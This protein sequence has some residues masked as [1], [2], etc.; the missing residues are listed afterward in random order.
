LYAAA[1]FNLAFEARVEELQL[2]AALSES[3]IAERFRAAE[4]QIEMLF[5]QPASLDAEPRPPP[6]PSQQD[7]QRTDPI[8]LPLPRGSAR[9]ILR[10]I[11]LALALA[12]G[13]LLFARDRG[14]SKLV[15]LAAKDLARLSPLLESGSLARGP[16]SFL[17][18]RI[19]SSRWFLMSRSERKSA[20]STLRN[21]L[22]GRKITAAVV[23]RD[24]NVLAIQIEQGRVLA[25]E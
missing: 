17:V 9:N 3:E 20:A 4:Q 14:S 22:I 11:G 1:G 13:I 15:P 21:H 7:R 16:D 5:G 24:D 25:V 12:G 19:P 10:G 2:L 8:P 23:F 6:A 18:G